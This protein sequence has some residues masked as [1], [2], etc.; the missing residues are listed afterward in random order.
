MFPQIY[1][2]YQH[3]PNKC[4]SFCFPNQ[5]F[6]H[7]T[8]Y[9][10]FQLSILNYNFVSRLFILSG[11]IFNRMYLF[12][13]E[14]HNHR[15]GNGSFFHHSLIPLL[16]FF[17]SFFIFS[18]ILY[19]FGINRFHHFIKISET[20]GFALIIVISLPL[21]SINH[22]Q[23][24]SVLARYNQICQHRFQRSTPI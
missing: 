7:H 6:N 2:F 16:L 12:A 20:K 3:Y 8:L 11:G 22:R 9:P 14:N 1:S 17:F 18:N 10:L 4:I 15:E 21:Y 23:F 19:L 5:I 13:D 24:Y